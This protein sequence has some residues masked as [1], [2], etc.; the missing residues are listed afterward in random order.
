MS[1]IHE[2]ANV[3]DHGPE[4]EYKEAPVEEDV[5]WLLE[6]PDKS[7]GSKYHDAGSCWTLIEAL[8]KR[9]QVQNQEPYIWWSPDRQGGA[10]C[11]GGTRIP[12]QLVITAMEAD[13]DPLK[14]WPHLTQ[15]QIDLALK[16]EGRT[17][18]LPHLKTDAYDKHTRLVY[19]TLADRPYHRTV[20]DVPCNLDLDHDG[21]VIGIECINW[22]KPYEKPTL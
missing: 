18:P 1:S 12:T 8:R 2:S 21:K 19:L 9:L 15:A 7:M 5:T 20:A 10:T 6:N 17:I 3:A 16:W 4:Y 11:I 14:M 13:Q 22:P